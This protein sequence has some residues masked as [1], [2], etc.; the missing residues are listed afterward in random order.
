MINE[1]LE[2]AVNEIYAVTGGICR[3]TSDQHTAAAVLDSNK[4][5]IAVSDPKIHEHS[6]TLNGAVEVEAAV[7]V[8]I[9]HPHSDNPTP[10]RDF[11]SKAIPK[12]IHICE[13]GFNPVFSAIRNT[14]HPGYLTTLPITHTVGE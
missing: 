7:E 5:V 2:T 4:P 3:V 9:I 8:W 10:A 13:G 1:I 11:F 12:L 6:L 14:Q